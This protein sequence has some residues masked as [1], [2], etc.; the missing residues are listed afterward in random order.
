MAAR[1]SYEAAEL[2]KLST[3][4]VGVSLVQECVLLITLRRP[5]K[6]N[7]INAD[8]YSTMAAALEWPALPGNEGVAAV[9]I[10]GTGRSFTSGADVSGGPP[11]T[12]VPLDKAPV[13][14]FMHAVVSAAEFALA[15][16]AKRN[17]K[18]QVDCTV[19]I[20]AAV[21]GPAVG[22]GATLMPHCVRARLSCRLGR[23]G[24]PS[25]SRRTLLWLPTLL[26]F[27]PPSC[28]MP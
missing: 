28:A 27:S 11:N 1:A 21:N 20:I 7:A 10:T 6:L 4:E 19:P 18:S 26:I 5:T 17:P 8:M 12:E 23:A 3:D 2:P 25:S 9:V 15:Q 13:A 14:D 16:H 22:I 24:A